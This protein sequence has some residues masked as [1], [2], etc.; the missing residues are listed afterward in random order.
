MARQVTQDEIAAFNSMR[1]SY[2]GKQFGASEMR[3][4]LGAIGFP[5]TAPFLT[6][7]SRGAIPPV[8]KTSFGKYTFDPQVVNIERMQTV[9]NLYAKGFNNGDEEYKQSPTPE[10]KPEDKDSIELAIEL[11]KSCGYKI[12]RPKKITIYEDV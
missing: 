3:N 12:Q 4:L 10:S 5:N 7:I 6:C 11:L 2:V 9:F 8:I 1:E